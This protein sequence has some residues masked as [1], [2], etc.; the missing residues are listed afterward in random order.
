MIT[1]GH[2]TKNGRIQQELPKT[3]ANDTY[4]I[5]GGNGQRRFGWM[6]RSKQVRKCNRK[7]FRGRRSHLKTTVVPGTYTGFRDS[8]RYAGI[9]LSVSFS[10]DEK[11]G[12][13][14]FVNW[15]DPKF[16]VA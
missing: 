11:Q 1:Y 16:T 2:I 9:G 13:S 3:H 10:A 15:M 8:I 7:L 4:I 6:C 5:V 14:I 12:T